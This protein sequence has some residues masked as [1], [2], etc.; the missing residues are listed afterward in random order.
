VIFNGGANYLN[1]IKMLCVAICSTVTL[2]AQISPFHGFSAARK[3]GHH[4]VGPIQPSNKFITVYYLSI[5]VAAL[6]KV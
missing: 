1:N 2:G 6:S 4:L 5:Q 3:M